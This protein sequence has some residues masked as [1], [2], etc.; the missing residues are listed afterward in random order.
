MHDHVDRIVEEAAMGTA[1]PDPGTG[2]RVTDAAGLRRLEDLGRADSATA[3]H[4]AANL[5][6]LVQRGFPVPSGVVIAADEAEEALPA[7]VAAVLAA[8]GDGPVAVRSSALAEDLAD[9]SFA[10]QY[11][12]VLGVSGADAVLEAVHRVRDTADD[13]RVV[14]YRQARGPEGADG[15]AVLVQRMVASDVSGVAFSANPLS[16]AREEAVVTATRG[17]GE[18]LVGGEAAGE[19]WVVRGGAASRDR[20]A[21]TEVLTEAQALAVADLA[22]RV[23]SAF[24]G[25]PQ[26][27]EWAFAAGEL[28]LLQA[29]P[30]T[31][32]PDPVTWES[33]LPGGWTRNFRIGEWLPEPVTPLCDTWLL[34]VMERRYAEMARELLG[35]YPPLPLHVTVNS[36]YFHSPT[37]AG[38]V[39]PT[40]MVGI[41]RHPRALWAFA[42]MRRP[43]VGDRLVF[44]PEIQR[45]RRDLLPRYLAVVERSSARVETADDEELCSVTND[46]AEVAGEYLQ[47]ISM[48]AGNAWKVEGA[49]AAFYARHLRPTLGGSHQ[50][51]VSGLEPPRPIAPYA[52]QS[53]DWFRPTAGELGISGGVPPAHDSVVEQ[54]KRAE[55]ACREALTPR[56]RASFDLLLALAQKYA[57]IREE[58]VLYLTLGWPLMRRA[59]ARL[60]DACVRRGVIGVSEDVYFLQR[61]EIAVN[62]SRASSVAERRTEWARH[63]KLCPPLLIGTLPKF[64]VKMQQDA[65]APMRTPA[66][67]RPGTIEGM[68]ASAGRATGV[69]RVLLDLADADRLGPGEVLVT[70]ATTPAWTP[71][72]ARAAAVVTDGGSLAAHATLVAREYGIPAVV[73]VGDA[74]Q[75][76]HDG[77]VVTVDGSAGL[78]EPHG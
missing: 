64:V 66:E 47:S 18:V 61:D 39:R 68:P 8:L 13:E 27:V 24:D 35:V 40:A 72:F 44:E 1:T 28:H 33:P 46:V 55:A 70:S 20:R 48:I 19:Q 43:Q 14:A 71:L 7:R 3:G 22:R 67:R 75:R 41:L 50:T 32:L 60:G 25:V 11:E 42:Q 4:K 9:A 58:Q 31:A 69:A 53:L 77:Q 12:T 30:M 49:L 62:E 23:E 52:I 5:G 10:G 37:G 17:L 2:A 16:G 15:I 6:W 54:R 78:V 63:R 34:P 45:W 56:Q 65:F 59:L 76:I 57:R 73:A 26:D 21:P 38:G 36:W 29:R 51:L 74:T